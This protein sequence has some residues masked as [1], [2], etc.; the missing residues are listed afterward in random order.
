MKLVRS[1]NA[2]LK[3]VSE[4]YWEI[5]QKLVR[6]LQKF[7][8]NQNFGK[9]ESF[10][11]FILKVILLKILD[12]VWSQ[13]NMVITLYGHNFI[14]HQT[15]QTM[16]EKSDKR[17][18]KMSERCP[19]DG[20]IKGLTEDPTKDPTWGLTDGPTK[21]PTDIFWTLVYTSKHLKIRREIYY[22]ILNKI[23]GTFLN[24]FSM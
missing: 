8:E 5:F 24:Q 13:L 2:F 1:T 12:F 19:K 10:F 15:W 14:Q 9:S 7:S 20:P 18:E 11:E 6:I 17:P 21:D 3:T 22:N 16:Q 23:L 4:T